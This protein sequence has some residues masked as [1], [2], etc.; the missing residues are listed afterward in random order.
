MNSTSVSKRISFV[1]WKKGIPRSRNLSRALGANDHYVEYFPDAPKILL[2]IRYLMQT[3]RTFILLIR[4]RP[5]VIIAMNPP[6]VLPLVCYWIS[7]ILGAKL[8][9][10]SHTG[11]LIGTWGRLLPIHRYL[12]GKALATI[13]TNCGLKQVIDSWGAEALVL[14][15]RLPD[16]PVHRATRLCN[17]SAVCV[18]NSFSEDEPLDE[19]L[20]AAGSMPGYRFYITGKLPPDAGELISKKP[21]NVYFTGFVPDDDYVTLLN[22]VDVIMIL[23]KTDHTMV[24]GAYESVSIEK[25]LITSDWPVLRRYFD[26][27]TLYTDNSPA[28]IS[29]AVSEAIDRKEELG[30]QMKELKKELPDRWRVHFENLQKLLYSEMDQ[31]APLTG[32]NF[33]RKESVL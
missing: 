2:P 21:G 17:D 5:Q 3:I 4:D 26:K 32:Q 27:G 25:P 18:I 28:D 24:C 11:A 20:D 30:G 31:S 23:V 1:S 29:R 9:I 6:L 10:D 22:A 8:V 19:I 15:D 14:E 16:L 12:S 13:V 33:P 7:K